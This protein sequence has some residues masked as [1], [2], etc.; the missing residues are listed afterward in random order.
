MEDQRIGYLPLNDRPVIRWPNGARIAFMVMPN[1]MWWE[2]LPPK[3]QP[4]DPWPRSP[5]PDVRGYAHQDFGNRVGFW[6]MLEVLDKHDVRCT[7][8][9][10]VAAL[11]HMPEVRDAMVERDWAFVAHGIYNTRTIWGYSEEVERAYYQDILDST[12]AVLGKP[13]KGVMG[14]A[15]QSGT[16]NTPDLLAEMG[17][18]YIAG[19][20][21]DDQP[22]PVNVKSG[23][24][25]SV[26]YSAEIS[27]VAVINRSS[28]EAPDLLEMVKRQFDYMYEESASNG[29]VMSINLHPYVIG[30][31]HRVGYLD[32]ALEYIL[33]HDGV[34]CATADELADYYVSAGYYDEAL[35]IIEQH[36]AAADRRG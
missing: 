2:F 7:S 30:Q 31:P 36:E 26:P 21:H 11:E 29:M 25:V 12:N 28:G 14:A 24:L 10:N 35:V 5:H 1:V 8:M 34:W 20:Y 17:F 16:S 6:R 18:R 27:D 9:A 22:T 33:S 23:K 19:W 4:R 15:A 3:D 13:V 32:K